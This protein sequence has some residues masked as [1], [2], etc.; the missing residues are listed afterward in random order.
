MHWVSEF[1]P[2]AFVN[3]FNWRAVLKSM[4]NGKDDILLFNEALLLVDRAPLLSSKASEGLAKIS[5]VNAASF[6]NDEEAFDEA[7]AFNADDV[8]LLVV[9]LVVD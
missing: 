6:I 8:E 2:A 7:V 3:A 1:K 9:W 4:L 5:A